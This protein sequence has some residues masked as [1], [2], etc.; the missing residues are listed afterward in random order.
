MEG[1]VN[2]KNFKRTLFVWIAIVILAIVVGIIGDIIL[3]SAIN[4]E[5]HNM[6]AFWIGCA[7][8]ISGC[9][10]T[11]PGIGMLSSVVYKYNEAKQKAADMKHEAEI[12]PFAKEYLKN[13]YGY[14]K[15]NSEIFCKDGKV[16]CR[17]ITEVKEIVIEITID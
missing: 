6:T 3:S 10:I 9:A 5:P 11:I 17:P 16:Y 4:S 1:N 2:M 15:T 7:M 13:K 14:D 8:L 12:L